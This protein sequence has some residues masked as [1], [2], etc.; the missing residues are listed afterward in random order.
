MALG[1]SNLSS[2]RTRSDVINRLIGFSSYR[3]YYTDNDTLYGCWNSFNFVTQNLKEWADETTIGVNTK[4]DLNKLSNLLLQVIEETNKINKK[5]I[6]FCDEQD[7][8]NGVKSV[9]VIL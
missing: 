7:K 9:A 2:V 8:I 3:G 1:N 6:I 5:I 4:Q